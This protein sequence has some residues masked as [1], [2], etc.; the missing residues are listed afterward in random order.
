M[1]A[2]FCFASV[3]RSKGIQSDKNIDAT[4]ARNEDD[5]RVKFQ[6]IIKQIILKQISVF[7]LI[8]VF[9]QRQTMTQI[10]TTYHSR[11]RNKLRKTTP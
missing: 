9:T 7:V 2:Q 6:E 10:I 1:M 11:A 4:K 3:D 8:N 5:G